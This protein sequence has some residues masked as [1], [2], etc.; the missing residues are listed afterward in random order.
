MRALICIGLV[1]V[2]ALAGCGSKQGH[3]IPAS[4]AQSLVAGLDRVGSQFDSGACNG[5]QAKV[6]D[7]QDA[8]ARLPSGV[9][10]EVKANIEAGL[11]RL[12][13]LVQRDCQRT[14]TTTTSSS[15]SSSSSSTVT[16]T[17]TTTSSSVTTTAT[18]TSTTSQDTGGVVPPNGG[19]APGGATSP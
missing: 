18:S 19:T 8:A 13:A 2:L 3:T 4:D 9:D 12:Q 10:P 1:V 5:A 6:R 7:L 11:R 15:S 17:T 16:S 14:Q